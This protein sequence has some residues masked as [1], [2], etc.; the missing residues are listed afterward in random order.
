MLGIELDTASVLKGSQVRWESARVYARFWA[1]LREGPL[2][3]SPGH[4]PWF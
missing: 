4:S 1:A 3:V 2:V